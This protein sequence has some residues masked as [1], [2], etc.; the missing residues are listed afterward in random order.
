MATEQS[1]PC[2]SLRANLWSKF[3]LGYSHSCRIQWIRSVFVCS[4]VGSPNCLTSVA[5]KEHSSW[6]ISMISFRTINRHR[7]LKTWKCI[8]S[9]NWK[10]IH[11][12]PVFFAPHSGRWVGN[13]CLSAVYSFRRYV[14]FLYYVR[15]IFFCSL[16]KKLI[17]VVRPLLILYLM[18]FFRPCST[19]PVSW[20]CF[21]AGCTILSALLSS[22][23][24]QLVSGSGWFGSQQWSSISIRIRSNVWLCKCVLPTTV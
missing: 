17:S 19:M 10:E 21:L 16:A 4:L 7:S 18:D 13:R 24:F 23:S 1:K 5:I 20:A 6:P 22:I 9:R 14:T 8:G 3:F 11:R 12:N 2:P 15:A